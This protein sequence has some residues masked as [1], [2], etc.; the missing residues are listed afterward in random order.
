MTHSRESL[1][2]HLSGLDLIQTGRLRQAI[3]GLTFACILLFGLSS[4]Q[5]GPILSGDLVV[6]RVGDGAAALGTTATPVFLDEFTPAGIPVQSITLPTTGTNSLTAVGNATTEGVITLSQDKSTLV[7]TGY[8][9]DAGGTNPSADAPATTNRV[10]ASVGLSGV[11]NSSTT[12]TDV[13]GTIRSANTV[14]GSSYY[15]GAS[16]GV[17]YAATPGP[18][19]TSVQIDS[20]NSREVQLVEN[21]LYAS[22]GSTAI[23]SKLQSY[24]TLPTGA[25]TATPLVDLT[26]ADAVNG[27]SLFD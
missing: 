25:T 18:L 17:R 6:F 21:V 3:F 9:K 10:I 11:V 22:N 26:T 5:G 14:N 13:T 4:A 8:R 27:F 12:L 1:R 7:F 23:T 24:G 19:V 20:R 15:V 2:V 16:T